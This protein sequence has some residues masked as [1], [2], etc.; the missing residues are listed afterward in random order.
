MSTARPGEHRL[1]GL[2]HGEGAVG[3][4]PPG[5]VEGPL[6]HLVR[7]AHLVEQPHLV[8]PPG[9]DLV[10]AEQQLHGGRERDL[11]GEPHGGP[12]AG[13]QAT[14]GLQHA[15]G[16][17]VG[18]HPEVAPAQHLHP[19]G[20]AG[21]VDGGHDRL[22]Q[23]DVAEDGLGPVVEPVAVDLGDP[24]LLQAG[25]EPGDLGDVGLEVG[26]H[27]EV[28]THAGDDRHPGVVVVAEPLPGHP[29]LGEVVHVQRVAGLG[30][31]DGDP[32]DVVV[33]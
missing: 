3:R 6:H 33:V 32:D 4:D 17:G 10:G 26:A 16:G 14:L 5:V 23:L 29:Q 21:A 25:R 7:G 12:A 15:E 18:R 11:A 13:E 28:G 20:H 30:T 27:A 31:V 22:V 8:G 2:A 9:R 1:L 24:G 19:P